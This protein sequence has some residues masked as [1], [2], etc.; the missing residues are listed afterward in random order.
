[1]ADVPAEAGPDKAGAIVVGAGS[2]RRLGGV[3][4]A[5]LPLL[6][7]PMI[8]YCVEALEASG[9]VDAI[10]LVLAE[11]SVGRGLAL[12]RDRG[13]TKVAAVVAGGAERQDSVRAGLNAL[14]PCEWVL[15]HDAA[16]PLLSPDIVR[17][18]LAAARISGAAVAAVPVRDTLKRVRGAPDRPVVAETVQR[19]ALWAAQTPQVFRA[20]LLRRAFAAAGDSIGAFTDDASLVEAMGHDVHVFEGS[21]GNLK[22]TLPEDVA[23]AE[24]LLRARA[25]ATSE[26]S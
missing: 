4:K 25:A 3:E 21:G 10:C 6:G 12:V 1:M 5:F 16:R 19:T 22:V 8:V 17:R 26:R 24:A 20:A 9:E 23:A 18:G 2:G 11:A 14:P 13:W 7:R 15:V